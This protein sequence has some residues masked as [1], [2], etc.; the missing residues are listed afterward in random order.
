[1]VDAKDLSRLNDRAGEFPGASEDYFKGF[2]A[3]FG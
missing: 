2:G 1:L 3:L